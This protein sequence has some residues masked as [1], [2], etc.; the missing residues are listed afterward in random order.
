MRRFLVL[1]VSCAAL[2]APAGPAAASASP[3]PAGTAKLQPPTAGTGSHL[4]LDAQGQ[5]GAGFH[6]QEI[7]TGMALTLQRGF[8]LTPGAVAGVCP[9]DLA[10]NDRCPPNAIIGT[11]TLDV[12][13]EGFAFGPNGQRFT[14][15]L[16]FYRAEP[17]QPGD[18]MGVVFSFRETSSGFHGASIGRVHDTGDPLLGLEARWDQLPIPQLPPGLHFTLER[19]RADIGAGAATPPVRVQ[20]TK[21]KRRHRCRKVTRRTSSGRRKTVF[22]CRKK[23]RRARSSTAAGARAAQ[24]GGQAALLTNPPTCAGSWRVRIELVYKSATEQR[25]ADAP[26]SAR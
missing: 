15:Q 8:A 11:G 26:C 9:D 7:P 10:T 22:V 2:C 16:T 25:D 23:H 24:A 21:K 1:L 3:A 19:L 20:A 4:L 13:G 14:A 5:A 17:R 12:L 6:R 18:P